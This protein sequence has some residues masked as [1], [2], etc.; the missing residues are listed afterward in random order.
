M[1]DIDGKLTELLN[2]QEAQTTALP[3]AGGYGVTTAQAADAYVAAQNVSTGASAALDPTNVIVADATNNG[4]ISGA[5]TLDYNGA[6]SILQDAAGGGMTA[7]KLA[8][9][10]AIAQ[11][12]NATGANAI[13]TSAY[14]KQM[15]DNVVLGN[16]ANAAIGD[17]TANS[18]SAQTTSLIG[19]WFQGTDN[20]TINSGSQYESFAS[21]SLFANGAPSASDIN[22]GNVTDSA[23]LSSLSS[24]A[25]TNPNAIENMFTDN[26]NGTYGVR[27]YLNGQA[28]YVT[29]DSQLAVM[30]SGTANDGSSLEYDNST[31]GSKWGQLAEKAYAEFLSE[32][33]GGSN[34]MANLQMD[35]DSFLYSGLNESLADFSQTSLQDVSTT[36]YNLTSDTAANSHYT[37]MKNFLGTQITT[38]LSSGNAVTMNC[39]ASGF[40]GQ[41]FETN[42]LVADHSFAVTA[43]N[44][45]TQT[46]TLDN[47]WNADGS[48][49]TTKFTM[50][51]DDLAAEGVT[52]NVN[53]GTIMTSS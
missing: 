47:P 19:K 31:N 51:L 16:T 15:F 4:W 20:P 27:F 11:N 46:V 44:A 24:L 25:A 37:A 53:G 41:V 3:D 35:G 38:A 43:Y 7:E 1:V 18:T 12:L 6:L 42:D 33:N 21:E 22:Q 40:T 34:D 17:L 28:Q 30:N 48:H 26:G 10:Q 5:N 32:V 50:S 8:G 23:F 39:N 14:V 49:V 45:T 9:L 36:Q 2:Y 29:V 13:T 52:F